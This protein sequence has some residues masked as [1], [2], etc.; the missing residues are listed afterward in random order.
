MFSCA[1]SP[2][3]P[4]PPHP[5]LIRPSSLISVACL[6]IF[7]KRIYTVRTLLGLVSF[8]HQNICEILPDLV[9]MGI[10]AVSVVSFFFSLFSFMA[11]PVAHGRSQ[12]KD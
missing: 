2:F 7:Y 4:L 9:E 1:P 12:A 6:L 11:A 5:L 10:T 8:A 3:S